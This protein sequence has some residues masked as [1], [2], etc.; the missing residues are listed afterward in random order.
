MALSLT[1]GE[2]G[3]RAWLSGS[4]WGAFAGEAWKQEGK[5]GAEREREERERMR[6]QKSRH[7]SGNKLPC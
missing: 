3:Q 4:C 7:E 6:I 1:G 5:A 2:A